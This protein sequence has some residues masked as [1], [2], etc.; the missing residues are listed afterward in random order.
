MK[1]LLLLLMVLFFSGSLCAQGGW[2]QHEM[3]VKI[4]LQ[5]KE[6]AKTLQ[7]LGFETEAASADG[8]TV[9]G[10]LLPPDLLRLEASGLS[11][12]I[13]IP[14][15]NEHYKGFWNNPVPPGYMTYEQ[16]VALAD[17]LS[18]AFPSICKKVVLGTSYGGREIAA[19]KISDNAGTDEPEPEILFDAGIHGDEILNSD[20]LI[21]FARDLCT[22]Y[23]TNPQYNGLINSREIW[24]YYMVNPD[25]RVNMTRDNL[26]GVDCNRD[27]GYMWDATSSSPAP[28][29]QT[30]TRILRNCLLDNQFV[31]YTNYHGGTEVIAYPWSYRSSSTPD[32]PHIDQLAGLY[33]TKSGYP[34]LPYGQG[35]NIM[36]AINGSTKDVQYGCFGNVGWSIET[37]LAKQPDYS[38]FMY[39][40][41]NNLPAMLEMIKRSG[42][43]VE[44]MVTDS[45][46]GDPV[47]ATIW[48]DGFYPVN[49][50]PQVG[51]YHKYILPGTH[52]IRV[53][54]NGYKT[55]SF[56]NAVVPDSGSV[57]RDFQLAPLQK[58]YG[59]RVIS[60]QIPGNNPGDEAYTPG[61]LGAPDNIAYSLG[62]SGW[63]ILDLGDTLFNGAGNDI[64]VYEASGTAEG[65]S[66]FA[67]TSMDGPW[68]SL[69][70]GMGT[71]SFDLALAAGGVIGKARYLKILD[72][73]DGQATGGDTGFDLDA[74]E[75]LTLPLIPSF[76]ASNEHPCS[77]TDVLFTDHSKGNPTSWNWS[78]P[79][80]MPASSNL[81]HPGAIKYNLP[82]NYDVALTISNGFSS[83]TT[84]EYGLIQVLPA[85]FVSLGNDTIVQASASILLDA[86]NPGFSYAWSTGATTQS[87]S[88]DSSGTGTGTAAIS[89]TVTD[90]NGCTGSDTIHISFSG[91][92]GAPQME[93][94]NNIL[95]FPNPGNGLFII[96][97]DLQTEGTLEIIS[98][99]GESK[100]AKNIYPYEKEVVAD[101][102]DQPPGIYLLKFTGKHSR[103]LRKI[104]LEK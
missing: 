57:I 33:S 1:N 63:I 72:D 97:T 66:C 88:V 54:A 75:M 17:S 31:V 53:T 41:N 23:A 58:Y 56:L 78:F 51:D 82:G 59:Y 50:D 25:G 4:F 38:M 76:S 55:K 39:Y 69:G 11:F 79:G 34:S 77:S 15:L 3:E 44:G 43:G 12:N 22:G 7:K 92:N 19:L 68:V 85:P 89:V 64:K 16:I 26:N 20:I 42:Y 48:V 62:K 28:Y 65:Y 35:Y 14:D 40:Y 95:V 46:T 9:N 94:S 73:G 30:E 13:S 99:T 24:I 61:A 93:S 87:I 98:F 52:S 10:Y 86:G 103:T 18:G 100:L 49:N 27:C 60:C 104:I 74:V 36:Y 84:R 29:S 2:K 96:M 83:G 102:S 45:V 37:S 71:T 101:L 81:Q 90:I 21:R 80:G 5:D 32:L 6:D 70:T 47:R 67:G 91:T 8:R